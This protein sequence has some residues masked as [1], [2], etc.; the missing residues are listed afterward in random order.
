MWDIVP[1]E[2]HSAVFPFQNLDHRPISWLSGYTGI[3]IFKNSG[4]GIFTTFS[5]INYLYN[6]C[7]ISNITNFNMIVNCDA[8]FYFVFGKKEWTNELTNRQLLLLYLICQR[9]LV[10]EVVYIWWMMLHQYLPEIG[11]IPLKGQSHLLSEIVVISLIQTHNHHW[12]ALGHEDR[13]SQRSLCK[14]P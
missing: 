7:Q 3:C 2:T 10:G 14:L 13:Y 9:A 11:V 5:Q 12:G 8:I 6:M 1:S 4:T